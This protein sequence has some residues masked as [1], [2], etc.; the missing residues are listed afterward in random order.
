MSGG[1]SLKRFLSISESAAKL[2]IHSVSIESLMS[3]HVTVV[4]HRFHVRGP[5]IIKRKK[6]GLAC[7]D[8]PDQSQRP[9]DQREPRFHSKP[10]QMD[11]PQMCRDWVI[12][13]GSNER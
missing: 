5:N 8:D 3:G 12:K 10:F 6:Y 11:D 2:F 7:M 4:L 9:E 1:R 13:G